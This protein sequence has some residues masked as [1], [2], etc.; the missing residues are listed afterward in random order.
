MEW[1]KSWLTM[2]R[3]QCLFVDSVSGKEV[4]LYVDCYG[5][6]YM[7]EYNRFGFRVARQRGVSDDLRI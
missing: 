7:A 4:F 6:E 2:K 3:K 1:I 5:D